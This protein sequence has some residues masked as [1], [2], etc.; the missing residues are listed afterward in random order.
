METTSGIRMTHV[1]VMPNIGQAFACLEQSMLS[2]PEKQRGN[3]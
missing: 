2:N 3:F 1:Q